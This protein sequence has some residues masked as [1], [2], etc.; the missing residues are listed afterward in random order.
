[1]KPCPFCH[2]MDLEVQHGA[3]TSGS[4]VP[5]NIVCADCGACGP[6]EY[7][8]GSYTLEV[9]ECAERTGWNKR[10]GDVSP[11]FTTPEARKGKNHETE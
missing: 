3:P 10:A 11:N 2:S 1:M 6:V 8:Y 7:F 9:D 5:H 4:L